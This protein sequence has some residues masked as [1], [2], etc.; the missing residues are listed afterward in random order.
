MLAG[1]CAAFF[2]GD[3]FLSVLAA[4]RESTGFLWGVAGFGLAQILWSVGQWREARP[5][6]RMVLGWRL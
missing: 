5:D 4:S 2:V 6:G 1:F 3:L